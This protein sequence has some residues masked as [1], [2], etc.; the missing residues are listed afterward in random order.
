[1]KCVFQS[2]ARERICYNSSCFYREHTTMLFS[3]PI[4]R[5]DVRKPAQQ[6]Y[7]TRHSPLHVT[8]TYTLMLY[9][10]QFVDVYLNFAQFAHRKH[11]TFFRCPHQRSFQLKLTHKLE[12]ASFT[13]IVQAK[14][15]DSLSPRFTTTI[16]IKLSLSR[17]ALWK[18][19]RSDLCG[20]FAT[21]P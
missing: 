9:G 11:V 16:A 2:S 3:V 5:V 14:G 15:G 8:P 12:I 7:R 17:T 10:V 1:M 6:F 21:V 4:N 13:A 18:A 20:M 19:I